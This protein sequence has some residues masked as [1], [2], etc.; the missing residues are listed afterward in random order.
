MLKI[1]TTV[2]KP[3]DQTMTSKPI[4]MAEVQLAGLD[5][6]A[7]H[8]VVAQI[9]GLAVE[10][11]PPHCGTGWHVWLLATGVA[12][13]PSTD[14]NQGGPLMDKYAKG[15]GI[16]EGSEPPRFRAFARDNGPEGFQRIA[17]GETILL[18]FCRAL[19]R[20]HHGDTVLVPEVL[21]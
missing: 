1:A 2:V 6:P 17:S 18:A 7:L 13:R 4:E 9:A 14:W 16:V 3:A 12:F 10:L 20:V 21:I 5:G 19:I 11:A 8:W 15:F